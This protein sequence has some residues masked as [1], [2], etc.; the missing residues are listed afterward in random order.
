M[1]ADPVPTRLEVAA[2]DTE[3]RA[4]ERDAVRVVLR[5]LDQEG[6][7]LPFFE[8]PVQLSLAGDGRIQGPSAITF[9]GGA[10]GF[11]VEAGDTAGKLD[12][13]V[14]CGPFGDQ[15]LTFTVGDQ[16]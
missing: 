16:A 11:W 3:L 1:P 9:K 8:E 13:T 14:S 12:L 10:T 5:V 15:T 4:G 7:L 6:N 2:D